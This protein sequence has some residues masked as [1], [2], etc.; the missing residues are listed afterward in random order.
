MKT[1]LFFTCVSILTGLVYVLLPQYSAVAQVGKCTSLSQAYISC[2]DVSGRNRTKIDIG[3]RYAGSQE[4]QGDVGQGLDV[5]GNYGPFKFTVP[6]DPISLPNVPR[7]EA[8][9]ESVEIFVPLRP[10]YPLEP[11][12]QKVPRRTPGRATWSRP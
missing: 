4:Y 8:S 9:S 6:N 11:F 12:L 5:T 10:L 3:Q 7:T 2:S 1:V